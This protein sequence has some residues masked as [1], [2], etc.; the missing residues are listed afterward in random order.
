LLTSNSDDQKSEEIEIPQ[1]GLSKPSDRLSSSFKSG[2]SGGSV[3]K[4]GSSR[5]S[6][7]QLVKVDTFKPESLDN[8]YII[9]IKSGKKDEKSKIEKKST[10]LPSANYE[11]PKS[12]DK[13]E[14]KLKK[15]SKDYKRKSKEEKPLGD[16][17]K[18]SNEQMCSHHTTMVPPSDVLEQ[19]KSFELQSKCQAF[20]L[21]SSGHDR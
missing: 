16:D 18:E 12:N 17:K 2:S 11:K 6:S 4:G 3:Q 9:N 13:P 21:K 14:N 5:S 20:H 8:P 7:S 1:T 15:H 10:P 19:L